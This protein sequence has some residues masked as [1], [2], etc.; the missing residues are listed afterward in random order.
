[1]YQSLLD[2]GIFDLNNKALVED[3]INIFLVS[4]GARHACLIESSNIRDLKKYQQIRD[5]FSHPIGNLNSL[6]KAIASPRLLIYDSEYEDIAQ[7][8]PFDDKYMGEILG[9]FSP[10]SNKYRF[11]YSYVLKCKKFLNGKELNLTAEVSE[12]SILPQALKKVELWRRHLNH[13][14]PQFELEV[15]EEIN[16]PMSDQ[17]EALTLF[18]Y[19]GKKLEDHM[20]EELIN[21]MSNLGF[22]KT[23]ELMAQENDEVDKKYAF[24]WGIIL[25][26]I[27]NDPMEVFYPLSQIT[28]DK[29]NTKIL[30]WEQT[31]Y[32]MMDN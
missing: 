14:L 28:S 7:K 13:I 5:Y 24:L 26:Y 29:I 30:T 3:L 18:I 31:L 21:S 1:M 11:S 25:S 9:Y 2:T 12:V 4:S 8:A 10:Y 16:Y 17:W 32:D 22:D 23:V 15:V 6:E 27:I 20:R 19:Q